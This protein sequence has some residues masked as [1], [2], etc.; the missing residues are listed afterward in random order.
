M[1]A[2]EGMGFLMQAGRYDRRSNFPM[3][4][5]GPDGRFTHHP[6]VDKYLLVAASDG[7]YA[8]ATQDEF[9]KSSK[10]VL[11]PWGKIEGVVWI[12]AR[13]GADEEVAYHADIS[14]RGGQYYNLG[15]GNG[16]RT[17]ARGRFAFDRVAPGRGTVGRV[18]NQNTVWGWLE[19]VVVE[20]GRTA[21]VRVG[22]RG[23][24]VI[25][26]LVLD[27]EPGTPIDWTRNPPVV[28]EDAGRRSQ[29]SS[30]LDKDG[31]FRIEDVPP[32][33]YRLE[34]GTFVHRARGVGTPVGWA[35]SDFDVPEAPAGRS[36][37]P[38]DLGAIAA[39]LTPNVGDKAPGF[40]V[41]RIDGEGKGDRLRLGDERGKVVLIDFWATWCAPCV[42]ELPAL[43]DIQE[44][45]GG[46]PRFRLISL[47]CDETA[48][49]VL[50]A[51]KEKGLGWAH[52]LGGRFGSGVTAR[53]DVRGIPATFLIGPDGRILAKDLRGAALKEAVARA[54][55]ADDESKGRPK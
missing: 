49:P 44:T 28:I 31:R 34:V 43:K 21:R 18:L 8:D 54:L 25:G 33:K 40:D 51:I 35:H 12:G 36:D 52:G 1:L 53:Y 11:K 16:T 13:P 4:R 39:Y 24:A 20:P 30:D 9:A 50:R 5:T 6:K 46:D 27:G 3:V 23:R 45:F 2:T 26:R 7:G 47:S 10:L 38:L 55:K 14:L 22:G 32:G 19:P 29:F 41:E 37:Q 17:D 42:A 15:Y 48:E